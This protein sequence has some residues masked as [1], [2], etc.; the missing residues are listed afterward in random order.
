MVDEISEEAG[1]P[2]EWFGMKKHHIT[3]TYYWPIN[4]GNRRAF[5]RHLRENMGIGR[6]HVAAYY[7]QKRLLV[8]MLGRTPLFRKDMDFYDL[9]RKWATEVLKK[10]YATILINFHAHVRTTKHETEAIYE[11]SG[12]HPNR[13]HENL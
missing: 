6:W 9:M 1:I 8:K 12:G 7:L 3:T 5:F 10:K 11:C 13:S 4:K 2:R